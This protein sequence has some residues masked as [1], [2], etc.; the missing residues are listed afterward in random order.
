MEAR[1]PYKS[2]QC[3]VYK[4]FGH[5]KSQCW[6]KN[7]EA[8]VVKEEKEKEVEEKPFMAISEEPKQSG[9]VWLIDSGYS[10]HMSGEKSLFQNIVSTPSHSIKVGD[11]K[12]L[13]VEGIGKVT[14]CS[15]KGKLITLNNV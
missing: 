5:V 1:K 13:K 11:G 6:Y 14:L 3:F 7:K 9:G 4:K 2:V 15:S 12:S 10:N 8:N